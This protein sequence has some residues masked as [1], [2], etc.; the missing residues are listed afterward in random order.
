KH[1]FQSLINFEFKWNAK[2]MSYDELF[3][4]Y[5]SILNNELKEYGVLNYLSS[6]DDGSPFDPKRLKPYETANKLLLAP[7]A[8]QIYYG[9]ETARTLVI[10][11]AVG[12]ATLRSNMNWLALQ[13]NKNIQAIHLHWQKLGQFRNN[14]P[15]IGAGIHT[16]ITELPY[17]FKRTY[18]KANFTDKVVVGLDMNKGEKNLN[19]TG[20][21]EDNTSVKDAYS[22]TVAHV[23]NGK[24]TINSPYTIVLLEAN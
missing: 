16:K 4:H 21:F 15:A 18:T 14:H 2:D 17:T 7:G 19:V 12:D 11:N 3:S 23:K 5:S 20:V 10:P 13:Q 22:N 1:G 8:A 24:V 6:H 9:D